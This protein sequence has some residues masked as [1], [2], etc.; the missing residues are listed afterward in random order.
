MSIVNLRPIF[1]KAIMALD[2]AAEKISDEAMK[3]RDCELKI[4]AA[5]A[6]VILLSNSLHIM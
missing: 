3:I 4:T 2:T 1:R 5:A 6:Q